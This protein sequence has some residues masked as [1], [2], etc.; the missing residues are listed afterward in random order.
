[1]NNPTP[2]MDENKIFMRLM[3]IGSPISML[4]GAA[5]SAEF[6]KGKAVTD[7]WVDGLLQRS[8]E[9]KKAWDGIVE[10]VAEICKIVK[11]E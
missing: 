7:E 3:L 5:S 4:I 2:P 8:D 11:G 10:L 6:I 1:M 9:A